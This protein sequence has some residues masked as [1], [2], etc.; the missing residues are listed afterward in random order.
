ML[1]YNEL[2]KLVMSGVIDSDLSLIGASSIDITLDSDILVESMNGRI[3]DVSDK[4]DGGMRFDRVSIGENGFILNP[5]QFILASS[6]QYFNLPN[7]ISILY[8][9]KSSM[10]RVG[11]NHLNAG[12][13]D[14]GWHGKLTLELVNVSQYHAHRLRAGMKIGQILFFEVDHVPDEKSYRANGRYNGQYGVTEGKG[15]I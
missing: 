5:G 15:V 4:S 14:P 2:L 7:N 3:I 11:L 12:F 6:E 13:G 10:A 9:L 1:S 8:V